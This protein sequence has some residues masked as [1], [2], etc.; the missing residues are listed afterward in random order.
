[1]T[2]NF[3]LPTA[4]VDYTA[5]GSVSYSPVTTSP[6]IKATGDKL[7]VLSDSIILYNINR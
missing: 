2:L 7:T 6:T 5:K 1:M 3:A 4:I